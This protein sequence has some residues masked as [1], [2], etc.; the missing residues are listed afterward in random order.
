MVEL[1]QKLAEGLDVVTEG[2][3]Q[4]T[5]AFPHAEFKFYFEAQPDTRAQRRLQE[6]SAQGKH[7]TYEEILAQLRERDRRD[8]TRDVAP[9]K[10]ADDA[11]RVDTTQLSIDEVVDLLE[12]TIRRRET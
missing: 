9:L 2:R 3:D 6:L 5:V 8:A 1:Q 7:A 11:I 12:Q 4:G 10:P